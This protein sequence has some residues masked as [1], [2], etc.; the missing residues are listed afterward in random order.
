[1]PAPRRR[2]PWLF[3]FAL[4]AAL[5]PA[6]AVAP[7]SSSAAL[8]PCVDG[9]RSMPIEFGNADRVANGCELGQWLAGMVGRQ[10]QLLSGLPSPDGAMACGARR[11][12]PIT[13]EGSFL[14]V[15][16]PSATAAWAVGY[17]RPGGPRPISA[18][19][20]GTSW[21]AINVPFSGAK[22]GSFADVAAIDFGTAWAVGD[23]LVQGRT[24]PLAMRYSNG[25]WSDFSPQIRSKH[26]GWS[27]L[28]DEG[29]GRN[30]VGRWLAIVR[31]MDASVGRQVRFA[32]MVRNPSGGGAG[33]ER[34]DHGHRVLG[35]GRWLGRRLRRANGRRR[36][37]P[38]IRAL[39]WHPLAARQTRHSR[40]ATP[41]PF[42]RWRSTVQGGRRWAV[43]S[44]ATTVHE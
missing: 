39:G 44:S 9:W 2:A 23:R 22:A 5:L 41:S 38:D 7:S 24:I 13:A 37:Q 4:T 35:V 11:P 34:I 30:R 17:K 31:R 21:S 26:R 43:T 28:R 33:S 16:S 42:C 19:W 8:G 3:A 6:A 25:A 36:V 32:R 14:G 12:S 20:N 10:E 15:S 29:S 18:R 27:D 1:M 40:R